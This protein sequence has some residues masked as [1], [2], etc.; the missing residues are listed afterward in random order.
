M[1]ISI[2]LVAALVGL[3]GFGAALTVRSKKDFA[4]QNEVVPGRPSP[5]P[6]SWA[7]SH[8]REAKLH[9][10]LGDAVRGAR[11]NPRFAELGLGAQMTAIENEAVAIDERLVAAANLPKGHRDAAIDPLESSVD[12]LEAT[13]VELVTSVTVADSRAQLD[14]A[15][16]SADIK[17]QALAEARAEIEM[18]DRE[19]SGTSLGTPAP[20]ATRPATQPPTAEPPIGPPTQSTPGTTSPPTTPSAPTTE[21]PAPPAPP[22]PA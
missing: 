9:R 4:E 2:L 6:A 20:P 8:T 22:P 17:L 15:V 21:T 13:I 1:I 11:E 18:I 3:V 14:A 10:R 16:S 12:A 7:G 5:A 19:A